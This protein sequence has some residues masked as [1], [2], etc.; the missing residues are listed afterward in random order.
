MLIAIFAVPYLGDADKISLN[1]LYEV[2]CIA[3]VFPL[4]VW[5]GACGVA[6]NK[7]TER[8]NK[9]LGKISYPLYIIHYPVM[10]L[11]YMWLINNQY[12]GLKDTILAPVLVIVVSVAMAYAALKLYDEPVRRW[13]SKKLIK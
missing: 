7:A 11:F 6:E 12:Y 9:F 10:Y 2:A 8:I 13:L 1:S 3:F 5:L 4:I